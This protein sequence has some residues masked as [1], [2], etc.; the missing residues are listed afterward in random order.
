MNN[1]AQH[2]FICILPTVVIAV[3]TCS[4]GEVLGMEVKLAWDACNWP[5]LAG[6]KVHY[7]TASKAYNTSI[8]VHNVTS[9][10]VT[11][12]A[13]GAYY[14]A[15]TAYDSAGVETAF[16]NEVSTGEGG[17]GQGCNVNGSGSANMNDPAST[18][19]VQIIPHVV[20]SAELRSNLGINN[21][22]DGFATVTV[23]LINKDGTEVAAK[24]FA[25]P[26]KGLRQVNRV[27]TELRGSGDG[28]AFE[29]Y[30]WLES[31]LPIGAWVSE[32]DNA[33]NDPGFV[34][35]K[36][37]GLV[38]QLVGSTSNL[39]VFR[40]TLVVVNTGEQAATVNITMRDVEGRIR[41]G[42]KGLKIPAHGFYSTPNILESLGISDAFGPLEVLSTNGQPLVVTSR[43][44]TSSG[45]SGFLG[46]QPLE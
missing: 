20:E 40:S 21:V 12:L 9:Y 7:G 41:G 30:L 15:V 44:Y 13:S 10:T 34:I 1:L 11:S 39:G 46:S 26:P 3:L 6:Y 2:R 29:G 42:L 22:S 14:F 35:G 38:H 23:R 17:C 33:T 28:S 18:G 32:I 27:V 36:T 25:I 37:K 24:P 31:N 5:G 43:V 16:S 8:N 19:L 4:P 45:T